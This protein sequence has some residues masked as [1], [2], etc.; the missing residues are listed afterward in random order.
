[1]DVA[2][3]FAHPG[4]S[5][6]MMHGIVSCQTL[7]LEGFSMEFDDSYGP[8][9]RCLL[10]CFAEFWPKTRAVGSEKLCVLLINPD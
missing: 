7:Y 6:V 4:H 2:G 3:I 9:T 1:V 8:E 5:A 10:H